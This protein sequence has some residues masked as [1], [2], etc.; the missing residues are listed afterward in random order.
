M[1]VTVDASRFFRSL[2][3]MKVTVRRRRGVMRKA[4]GAV[5]D[6]MRDTITLQGRTTKWKPLS[7]WT[8]ARTGRRKALLPLR[9]MLKNRWSNSSAEVFLDNPKGTFTL[10]QHHRGYSSRAVRNKKMVVPKAGG[11]I[12]A[13]FVNRRISRT[14]ARRIVPTKRETQKIINPIFT[15]WLA[16]EAKRKWR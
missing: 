2:E 14:P 8:K 4:S 5:R 1:A 3:R 13:I 15:A 16:N 10:E 6:Y 7:P 9:P 11:G 12:L